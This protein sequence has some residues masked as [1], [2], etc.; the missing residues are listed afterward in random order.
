M[1]K[2]IRQNSINLFSTGYMCYTPIFND[3]GMVE[4]FMILD[5]NH[6]FEAITGLRNLSFLK[7]KATLAFA[8]IKDSDFDWIGFCREAVRNGIGQETSCYAGIHGFRYRITAYS[9]DKMHFV[10]LLEKILDPQDSQASEDPSQSLEMMFGSHTAV[11]LITEPISGRIV[12][13]NSTACDFYG[14][15]RKDLLNMRLEDLSPLFKEEMIRRRFQPTKNYKYFLFP[16]RLKDGTI[17]LVDVYSFPIRYKKEV[18]I[19]SVIFDVTEKENYKEN[20]YRQKE[21]LRITFE[22]IGD[23]VVTTD[24]DGFVTSLNKSAQ[25]IT[26][27]KNTEAQGRKFMDVFKLKNEET[28][29]VAKDP[30]AMVLQTGEIIGLANHTILIDKQGRPIPVADSAAPIRDEKGNIFGVVMVFRNI[31]HEREQQ[32]YILELSYHDSLTGLYNRTFLSKKLPEL[33][34]VKNLPL[35]LIIGDVNGLKLINDTFGHLEGDRLLKKVADSLKESCRKKDIIVRWG[36][37]EFLIILPKTSAKEA[38]DITQQIQEA[39]VR[40]RD[41]ILRISVSLSYAVKENS[42]ENL[43]DI[44]KNAEKWMYYK[45]MLEEDSQRNNIISTLLTTLYVNNIETEEHSKR[46]RVYCHAIGEKL[47]LSSN[48]QNELFLLAIFHDIG[49]IGIHENIIQKPGPLSPEEYKEIQRHSE[50][51]YHIIRNVPEL[52]SVSEYILLHHERWDGKGYPKGYQREKI[53]LLCRILAVADAYDVMITGR[54]YQKPRNHKEAITELQRNAGT[55]FDP[56]IVQIF[57]EIAS[58]QELTIS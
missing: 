12:D 18:Y 29:K 19:F 21:L 52:S 20:L 53:P 14:C 35:A 33:D 27:W 4:D 28:G 41:R 36:G 23:G 22:S 11:M 34:T 16:H 37:D 48:E 30:I 8:G 58:N 2:E 56:V 7:K 40:N 43:Q 17:R 57:S 54:I 38:K 10:M 49:K 44:L 55:Q 15:T 13:I 45:K 32:N 50:I 6:A 9:P 47:H 1:E 26:G 24:K 5:A 46:V 42:S 25:K 31:S 51:G 3:K 39:F